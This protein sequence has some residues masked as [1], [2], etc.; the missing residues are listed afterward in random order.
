MSLFSFKAVDAH[1]DIPCGIYETDTVTH[2]ANTCVRMIEKIEA[3]GEV[4]NNE[5]H[6]TFIR[7]I[8]VKEKHAERVKHELA[9]L[10]GDYFKP[11]HLER[12]PDLHD[13]VW[14]TLKQ[15]SKVKQ[16]VSMEEAKKLQDMVHEIGHRFAESKQT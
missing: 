9:V 5:K 8:M 7:C 1:C 16:S 13:R 2:A 14:H 3:L 11:E 15:A 6:N 4:D 12:F 10:W